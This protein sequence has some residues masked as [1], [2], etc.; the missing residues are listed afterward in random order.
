MASPCFRDE[1]I[2]QTSSFFIELH[3]WIF[4]TCCQ[5]RTLSSYLERHSWG[6]FRA[7]CPQTVDRYLQHYSTQCQVVSHLAAFSIF[8]AFAVAFCSQYTSHQNFQE[9]TCIKGNTA[10]I[11][12]CTRTGD[13]NSLFWHDSKLVVSEPSL[14]STYH[15][16]SHQLHSE[17]KPPRYPGLKSWCQ[18]PWNQ[19][20]MQGMLAFTTLH[21]SLLLDLITFWCYWELWLRKFQHRSH[22]ETNI[23]GSKEGCV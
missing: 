20:L 6:W 12:W 19:M 1:L 9:Q 5:Y 21:T 16:A 10:L 22:V 14:V 17:F 2:L 13:R 8:K 23:S 11:T 7:L 15:Q 18:V 3:H 4:A